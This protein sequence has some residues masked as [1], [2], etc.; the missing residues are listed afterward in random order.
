M[1]AQVGGYGR[2]MRNEDQFWWGVRNCNA[3]VMVAVLTVRCEICV[4]TW[5][6]YT[7]QESCVNMGTDPCQ[8]QTVMQ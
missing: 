2:T 7:Q 3:G 4:H 6:M 1:R 8:V 5:G